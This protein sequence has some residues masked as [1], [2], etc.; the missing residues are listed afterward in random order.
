[1]K[2][3]QKNTFYKAHTATIMLLVVVM[4]ISFT[5][6]IS[7]FEFDNVKDYNEDTKTVTIENAFGLGEDIVSATLNTP[8]VYQVRVGEKVKIARFTINP[9]TDYEN[10]LGEFKINNLKDNDKEITREIDVRY[11]GIEDY[12]VND[13]K[14][15]EVKKDNGTIKECVVSGSHIE[16]REAFIPWD[17]NAYANKEVIV[18]L[19]MDMYA[20]ETFDWKPIIAGVKVDEWAVVTSDAV[21]TTDGDYTVITYLNNGTF[22]TTADL[23]TSVLV[24]AGGGGGGGGHH[25]GGAGAG[26]LV[27]E[28]GFVIPAGNYDVIVGDGGVAGTELSTNGE[29]SSLH[30]ITAIGGGRTRSY[31]YGSGEDGGSGGGENGYGGGGVGSELQTESASGGFGTDGGAGY[32]SAPYNGGG[33]GGAG[34]VGQYSETEGG[35]GGEGKA[36]SIYNGTSLYYAGGGG[37]SSQDQAGGSGGLGGGG[38]GNS[39]PLGN[40]TD[41]TGGGAGGDHGS[42]FGGG[43]GGSGIVIIRALT[44]DIVPTATVSLEN[45]SNYTNY[46][47][48]NEIYFECLPVD[49]VNNIVNVTLYIDGVANETNTDGLNNT[50]ANF[51]NKILSEGTHDWTCEVYSNISES[52]TAEEFLLNVNTTPNIEFGAGVYADYSNITSDSFEVNV[53][54]TETFFNNVTFDL[55]VANSILN[56]TETFTDSTR[57]KTFTNIPDGTYSYNVTT[58]T[59]TGKYNQTA[60]RNISIDAGVPRLDIFYPTEDIAFHEINANLSLNWSVNDSNLDTCIINYNTTNLTVTCSTNQTNM[61]ISNY[62]YDNVSFWA[63]DT[64]GNVNYTFLEWDYRLFQESETFTTPVTEG[65]SPIFQI[66]LLTNGSDITIGNLSYNDLQNIGTITDNTDNFT[67]TKTI[68]A[69]IVTTDTNY[70]FFWRITQA[71]GFTYDLDSQNQTVNDISIDNCSTN[72][73]VLY[74]F[75]VVDEETQSE[76][77][78]AANNLT[79]KV[80]LKL[81]DLS[82]TNYLTN[83]STLFNETNPFA[84]CINSSIL[85][86]ESLVTD[87]QIQYGA[88]DYETELYHIQN[89]TITATTINMNKTLYDLLTSSSQAF[90]LVAKDSSFL[91]LGGAIIEVKRKYVEEGEFKIVEIPQ[92]DENGETVAHLVV[93][94]A[95]YNFVIKKFG[96]ILLTADNVIPICQTPLVTTCRIDFNNFATTIDVPDYESLEDFEYTLGYDSTTK[97]ISSVFNIPSDTPSEVILNVTTI[98]SLKTSVCTDTLT[99]TSGTISCVVPNTFGN[100]TV[101]AQIIRDDVEQARGSVK[102]DQDPSDIYGTSILFLGLFAMLT[103]IGASVSDN[104]IYTIIFFMLGIILLFSLNLVANNGFIGG[105]ATVLWL[106]VAI[107][108]VL[109]KG[110]RRN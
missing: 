101:L 105:S 90:K 25:S 86:G 77:D 51:T 84:I 28:V 24:V 74:N 53:T 43:D 80:D 68:T 44:S 65:T 27:Y 63:T 73:I 82:R 107:I 13:Y 31:N 94:D 79:T 89:E 57:T 109:I 35:A 78:E 58:W 95:V 66:V 69:P 87:V 76:I 42:A 72:T 48:T 19:Y 4:F 3:Q 93:N 55:Y 67:L 104:P 38:D 20:E 102:L 64:F 26:G 5:P 110:A 49:Y 33:G 71:G 45:P 61:N 16:Q 36:Y 62:G 39:W 52:Y 18:E 83:Y 41:G 92:T 37:G 23:N 106:I 88:D 91:A 47:A 56:A 50:L 85:S 81:M 59:T 10:L 2:K 34:Q 14:C 1:M 11:L 22:N 100:S 32:G 15:S 17:K 70:S 103:L 108:V 46:T 21:E 29:N 98:D 97:V 30:N 96:E 60:T 9:Y 12:S 7:S 40:G 75:T 6:I 99:S 8:Q 54:L